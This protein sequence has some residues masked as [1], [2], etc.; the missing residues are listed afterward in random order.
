M[1]HLHLPSAWKSRQ[2]QEGIVK[3]EREG[4]DQTIIG[5]KYD[6]EPA[7]QSRKHKPDTT[8]SLKASSGATE[9]VL[10]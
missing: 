10:D 4:Q 2:Q 1:D 5:P 7:L 9:G 8:S 3:E 6:E